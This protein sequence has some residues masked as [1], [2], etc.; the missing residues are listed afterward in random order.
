[1]I[2]FS[3]EALADLERIFEFN[4]ER[5]PA[6][7]LDHIEKIRGAVLLLDAHPE[8]GRRLPASTLRELVISHGK[9]GYVALYEHAPAEG[10]VR[11]AAIR[12][13]REVGYR[14]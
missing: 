2:V 9:S 3:E 12:H 1:V 6:T 5:H 11:I 14:G 7:A 10:L 4:F 8:I 13:Q